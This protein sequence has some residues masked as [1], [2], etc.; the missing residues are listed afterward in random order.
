MATRS[1]APHVRSVRTK[2]ERRRPTVFLRLK[3]DEQFVGHALFEPDPEL[4]DN[5]GFYEYFSHWDQQ[6]TRYVP[7]AGD[8]CPFCMANDSP[9]TQASTLWFLPDNP[10]KDQLKVFTMNFGTI[11][12]ITDISEEDDGILG[13]KYRVKRMSD[14]GEYRIRPLTDKALTKTEIKAL[15]KDAPDLE[16]MAEKNLKREWERLQAMDALADDEDDD[17]DEDET[18]RAA[19]RGKAAVDTDEDENDD[20]EEEDEEADE[21]DEDEDENDEEDEDEEDEDEDAEEDDEDEEDEAEE[22]EETSA[23]GGDEITAVPFE[24]VKANA[25][26]ENIDVKDSDGNKVTLFVGQDLEPDWDE[27]K[28]GVT[29]TVDALK[30]DEGDYVMTALKVKKARATRAASTTRRKTAARK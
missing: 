13:S 27:I 7:C 14:R 22:D 21:E 11:Q 30:D 4:A 19:R 26:D 24:V 6:G 18:P 16:D 17:D 28:K 9:M 29:I 3:T 23:E 8:Q 15:L 5:P 1:K 2:E 25:D 10:K 12:D 20:D